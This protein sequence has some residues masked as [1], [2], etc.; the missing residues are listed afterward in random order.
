MGD[1]AKAKKAAS[2]IFSIIDRVPEI[3]S[4]STNGDKLPHVHGDIHF[5]GIA[6]A[7]P[8]RPDAQIYKNYSLSI[9]SGQTV[10]LVGASGSGKSTAIS[11]LES[12]SRW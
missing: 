5:K 3:D 4:T 9:A 2:R 10:A 1:Q 11:L 7:Y 8:S 12:A 6:F